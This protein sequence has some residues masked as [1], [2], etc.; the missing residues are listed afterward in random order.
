MIAFRSLIGTSTRI[1]P[2]SSKNCS[3]KPAGN[4]VRRNESV[5]RG[6]E[7]MGSILVGGRASRRT[8]GK[9][10]PAESTVGSDSL[11]TEPNAERECGA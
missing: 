10:V 8:V 6:V 2:C 11:G 5:H 3:C 7:T 9:V 4:L 1:K